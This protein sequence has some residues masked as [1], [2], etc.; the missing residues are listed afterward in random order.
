MLLFQ[1]QDGI[2]I[3]IFGMYVQEYGDDCRNPIVLWVTSRIWIPSSISSR[4]DFVRSVVLVLLNNRITQHSNAHSNI[5]EYRH[6]EH[7]HQTQVRN[8]IRTSY[9]I[10]SIPRN[11]VSH[12]HT[13]GPVHRIPRMITSSTLTRKHRVPID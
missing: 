9:R 1:K 10:S 8:S 2:D 3:C 4:H 5:L 11:E 12:M 6:L 13:F 7:Q